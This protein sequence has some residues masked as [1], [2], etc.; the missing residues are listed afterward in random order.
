MLW[1]D[2]GTPLAVVEAK[3]TAV[4]PK[5]GREQAKQYAD[6][7][8]AAHGARPVIFYTNGIDI[9]IWDDAQDQP[10]RKLCSF[11][12][13]DSVEY[14]IWQRTNK[15]Q[16]ELVAPNMDIAGRPYQVEGIKR[17][18]EHFSGNHRKALIVMATGTGKTRVAVS[19]SEVLSRAGWAKRILFLCDRRELH[20]QADN[21]FKEHLPGAP[22]TFVTAKTANDREQRVYLSTY[23][24]MIKRFE[25]FDVGFFDLIIADE[26]HRSIYNKYP[27][28]L[29]VLR[30]PPVGLT[31]TPR[32]LIT[33][34]TYKLFGC[35]KDDPTFYYG[36]E[37]ASK[38]RPPKPVPGREGH[39]PVSSA[40]ASS[41]AA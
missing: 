27:R 29:S 12:S 32:G 26:V 19:L 39:H 38:R 9:F 33:H 24:A 31:A 3:K 11:Y 5:E 15:E 23:P 18:R 16:L 37:G 20:N 6:A 17:V 10:P 36:L 8:E 40:K 28:H 4:D 14:L 22:R 21:A 1:G 41:T 30:R 25:L 35:E 34:N 2:S 7:L 13:K